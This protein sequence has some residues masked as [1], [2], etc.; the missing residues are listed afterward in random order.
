MKK[1]NCKLCS[2]EF[3]RYSS[4]VRNEN[5]VFCSISHKGEY[6]KVN[7]IQNGINNS[8]FNKKWSDEQR[9]EQSRLIKSKVDSVY[10][11][12]AGSANRGKLFSKERR[13]N[14]SRGLKGLK[15]KPF[16]EDTK[17]KIGIASKE[18]FTDEFKKKFRTTMEE[19]G[20]WIPLKLKSDWEMYKKES[21]WICRMFDIIDDDRD[22]L[23]TLGVFNA[24]TNKKG[25]VRDHRF[26]RK[27]GF[28]LG[29]F[30]LILRHPVN[31]EILTHSENVKKKLK[32]YIDGDSLTIEELFD[33]IKN[34][35]GVWKEHELCLELIEQF[36]KGARHARSLL[37]K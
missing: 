15:K 25:V 8:N 37:H 4:T 5:L 2:I 22:L 31:C 27:S 7:K 12:K 35:E 34:Y 29:V 33:K 13:E 14:I 16:S 9:L 10:R 1:Y 21:N 32:K 26:S 6:F 3:E 28:N 11:I 18:K 30:P 17:L 36:N 23:K 19:L 20:I 24:K